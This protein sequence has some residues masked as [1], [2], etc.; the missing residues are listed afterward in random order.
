MSVIERGK[1]L[2]IAREDSPE[3]VR[4]AIEVG[5]PF[6]P[7][8]TA[9][10]RLLLS[11]A[12]TT[13][14]ARDE[15]IEGVDDAVVRIGSPNAAVHAALAVSWLRSRKGAKKSSV[16]L[17]GLKAAARDIESSLGLKS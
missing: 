6:E 12:G 11:P 9:S 8:H 7:K 15:T 10:G 5:G 14:T 3:S 1:L 4:L 2:V 17:A 13:M 16:V